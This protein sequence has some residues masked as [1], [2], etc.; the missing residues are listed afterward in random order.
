MST[1]DIVLTPEEHAELSRRTRSAT[2]IQSDGRRAKVILLAAQGCS[3]GEVA[4]KVGFSLRSVTLCCQRFQEQGLDGL[5][6]KLGRG[7]KS[8]SPSEALARLLEQVVPTP[9]RPASPELPKDGICRGYFPDQRAAYMG[10]E[11]H[12]AGPDPHFQAAQRSQL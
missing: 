5:T 10:C 8:P 7:R 12:K 6:D 3:W 2:I 4:R 9:Y 11:S 1:Q